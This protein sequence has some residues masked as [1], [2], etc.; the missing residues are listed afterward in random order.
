MTL[1]LTIATNRQHACR[2][3]KQPEPEVH[4]GKGNAMPARLMPPALALV[5]L[6]AVHTSSASAGQGW[7]WL[8]PPM[9]AAEQAGKED[10][11]LLWAQ[12]IF[13]FSKW[14]LYKAFD[15]AR[16]CE[17]ALR[18]RLTENAKAGN[19]LMSQTRKAERPGNR[20]QV[21][22]LRNLLAAEDLGR[23]RFALAVCVAS[24]DPRLRPSR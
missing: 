22:E 11:P 3:T 10:D 13:P 6:V 15:S 20:E 1:V 7:Y 16:E 24:D 5:L 8:L 14:W 23:R 17:D 9:E 19:A 12:R 21:S 4:I 18:G 2:I